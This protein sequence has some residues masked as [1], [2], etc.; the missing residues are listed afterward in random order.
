MQ[1]R[2]TR[3][4]RGE[5]SGIQY[6]SLAIA[7]WKLWS[8][9]WVNPKWFTIP[10]ASVMQKAIFKHNK[11]PK[12]LLL[13]L[14]MPCLPASSVPNYPANEN[15]QEK[16]PRASFKNTCA[17]PGSTRKKMITHI[18][19][20]DPQQLYMQYPLDRSKKMYAGVLKTFFM[21]DEFIWHKSAKQG[22]SGSL[23]E[24]RASKFS[25]YTLKVHCYF[26]SHSS[27]ICI[28]YSLNHPFAW[29]IKDLRTNQPA[30]LV[31]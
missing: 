5:R 11:D 19:M 15:E 30:T 28:S 13:M 17:H 24:T 31:F 12:T 2:D 27:Q 8:Q 7:W 16:R 18:P 25:L 22:A 21:D 1:R 3:L 23:E 6:P 9:L 14:K 4:P 29:H 20:P 10:Q 26:V